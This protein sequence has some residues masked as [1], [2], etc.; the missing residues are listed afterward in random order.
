MTD[1]NT[2]TK[3]FEGL[4]LSEVTECDFIKLNHTLVLTVE[5][6]KIPD[7]YTVLSAV[8]EERNDGLFIMKV[9]FPDSSELAPKLD[10]TDL[11][12]SIFKHPDAP[13]WL[14]DG[15]SDAITDNSIMD[16]FDPD[17]IRAMM[18]FTTPK[19]KGEK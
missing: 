4:Y 8:Y 7:D 15:L 9:I 1:N 5:A 18:M 2:A 14:L 19:K 16:S 10:L 3:K 12:V 11:V 13:F 6:A 17:V